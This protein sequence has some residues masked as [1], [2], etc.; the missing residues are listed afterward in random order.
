MPDPVLTRG[1]NARKV[2]SEVYASSGHRKLLCE[3]SKLLKFNDFNLL[4][5]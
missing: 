2:I 1:T 4:T 5:K 3:L